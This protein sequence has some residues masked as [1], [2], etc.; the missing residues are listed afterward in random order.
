MRVVGYIRASTSDQ[1]LTLVAQGEKIR[2]YC[3]LYDLE[4]ADVVVGSG[5]SGK[6]LERPGIKRA[7]AALADLDGLV[8]TKLDRLTRDVGDWQDLING[9]FSERSGKHLFSVGDAIDTRSAAGRLVL[10]VLL[11]VAQW[12][13][14]AI[15]ERTREALG[16]QRRLGRRSAG[17]D[18][19]FG[20]DLSLDGVTLIENKNEQDALKTMR[21]LR[22]KGVALKAIAESLERDGVRPKRGKRWYASSIAGILNRR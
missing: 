15:S 10:N 1:Q 12:E 17:R 21:L 13:R 9:H 2:A 4:L 3:G 20:Y 22:T 16:Q 11:S 8:V 5:E 19:P 14:E 7:L 6:N 18:T